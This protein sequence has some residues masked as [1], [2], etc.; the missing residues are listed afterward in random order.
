MTCRCTDWFQVLTDQW[1][2]ID[3][4][5]KKMKKEKKNDRSYPCGLLNNED[6]H[7]RHFFT[8]SFIS[9]FLSNMH[10]TN[11]QRRINVDTTLAHCLDVDATLHRSHVSS[12]SI[13][14]ITADQ[15]WLKTLVFLVAT[16]VWI[17]A[18]TL[19]ITHPCIFTS[20]K[21]PLFW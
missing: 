14:H 16:R 6:R 7:A 5:C 20:P 1:K 17:G 3:M 18:H 9:D 10:K 12:L 15:V 19:T 11:R 21:C 13:L 4:G 8:L 2:E